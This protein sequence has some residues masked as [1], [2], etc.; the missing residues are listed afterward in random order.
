ML[1]NKK[2]PARRGVLEQINKQIKRCSTYQIQPDEL[3]GVN[4]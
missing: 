4:A 1:R 3:P 2:R